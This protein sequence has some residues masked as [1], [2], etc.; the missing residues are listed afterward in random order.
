MVSAK[1]VLASLGALVM[2]VACSGSVK[3]EPAR[4]LVQEGRALGE[5]GP[6]FP[7]ADLETKSTAGVARYPA[8]LRAAGSTLFFSAYVEHLQAELWMSDGTARG[9]RLLGDLN[10]G[11]DGSHPRD[12]LHLRGLTYFS[13]TD[14]VHGFELW[15]TDGTPEG[16]FLLKDLL[17]G[18]ENG[19]PSLLTELN[20]WLLFTSFESESGTSHALWRSDGT[21]AGTVRIVPSEWKRSVV[22]SFVVLGRHAYFL[23]TESAGGPR[24]WR[25]DGTEAGLELAPGVPALGST[26]S[27]PPL[28][29][30]GQAVYFARGSELWRTDGTEAGTVRVKNIRQV[31]GEGSSGLWALTVMGDVLYFMA[32]DGVHGPELWRTD[33]TEAGTRLV[34]DLLPSTSFSYLQRLTAAGDRLYFVVGDSS[35]MEALYVTDGTAQ[36][37]VKLAGFSH[38]VPL[39]KEMV[40]LGS[41]LYFVGYEHTT[42][43]ELWTSDGTP[44]GTRRLEEF[45][46]GYTSTDRFPHSLTVVGDTLFFAAPGADKQLALWKTGPVWN[47][48]PIGSELSPSFSSNPT[49]FAT[50]NGSLYFTTYEWNRRLRLWRSEGRAST[51]EVLEVAPAL[52]YNSAPHGLSLMVEMNGSL[53]FAADVG[54]KGLSVHKVDGATGAIQHVGGRI[55]SQASY[56]SRIGAS[57]A[58]GL[59]FF[60]GAAG[61]DSELWK[62]DGTPAGTVLVK[63]IYAGS[64]SPSSPAGFA[65]LGGAVY[66]SATSTS[67]RELWRTDGTEQGTLMV[68]DIVPGYA[69]AG[70][71]ALKVIGNVLYF[72]AHDSSGREL[73]RTDG[74]E[75]GTLRVKDIAPGSAS[76]SPSELAELGG[77]LYFAA[78]DGSSGHELWRSD[79]T[80]AGTWRVK[81]ITDGPS[82]SAPAS[83]AVLGD[84]L[85]FTADDGVHGRELWRTDGTEQG[86]VR[87]ANVGPGTASGLTSEALLPLPAEG[88]LLFAADDGVHGLELWLSDGTEAG[89]VMLHDIAPGAYGSAPA[90]LTLSGDLV[91]FSAEDGVHGREPWVLERARL[92]DTTPPSITCPADVTVEAVQA[93]GA[94]VRFQVVAASDNATAS[95]AILYSHPSGGFFQLGET[96]VTATARDHAGL[97]ARCTFT[98][99]VRDTTPPAP[100]CPQGATV[101]AVSEMGAVVSFPAPTATDAVTFTP[102]LTSSTQS[103][104]TFP[105]GATT[106]E[107]TATDEA[108][109]ANTCSFS[110]MVRDTVASVVTCPAAQVVEAVDGHGAPVTWPPATATDAVSTPSLSYDPGNGSRFPLGHTPVTATAT[111]GAGNI[112]SCTFLV[113]VRDTTAPALSCPGRLQVEATGP[114]G[115]KVDY[116]ASASDAVSKVSSWESHASGSTFPLGTT[117][118][119]LRAED[120]AGNTS[121]CT[122]LVGVADTTPPTLTCPEDVHAV[123]S[124]REGVAVVLPSATAMDAVTP[125]PALTLSPESGGVFAPG[126][127]PVVVTAT[128]AAGNTSTCTFT[129]QVEREASG[130]GA[131]PG[132]GGSAGW[133]GLALLFLKLK[134]TS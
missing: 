54:G 42:G 1:K 25:T 57:D 39:P 74:T 113:T 13:A 102:V 97:D 120:A 55:D 18:V 107:V 69:S 56:P 115:A 68:K 3:E 58:L 32:N 37:T 45:I 49:A 52:H 40:A 41:R 85:Y 77:I 61:Y 128:D 38:G 51:Q 67:G 20:G 48:L 22:G 83:F 104:A 114:E 75:Q 110:V 6:A 84:V 100:V 103:G 28:V 11:W 132:G 118:V 105:L 99:N 9:T 15:R 35:F 87:V 36:G 78:S 95:P 122:F 5:A 19:F 50:F 125:E 53:Y 129:V 108:G 24:L 111:D 43:Y 62:S 72:T 121:R 73:W 116:A 89:T 12:F 82:G 81:D 59:I 64:S 30:M 101:E 130:C 65:A 2:G 94:A 79:G 8:G 106:V 127:T 88:K 86:T 23:A 126:R 80:E 91:G 66:F 124:S 4:A 10:P 33:G 31:T 44:S 46:P 90:G 27:D 123:A 98:V 16:T 134:R 21:E 14:K 133:L 29:R 109:N 70:P 7:L 71:E 26:T 131:A 112:S 60:A 17:P 34:V 76:A 47:P 93:R 92:H 63:D 96:R 117:E 119:S